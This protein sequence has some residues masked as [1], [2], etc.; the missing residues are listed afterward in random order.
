VKLSAN[1]F[2]IGILFLS[3]ILLPQAEA[4]LPSVKTCVLVLAC[5]G[6]GAIGGTVT[7]LCSPTLRAIR[8]GFVDLETQAQMEEIQNTQLFL[9]ESLQ[10]SCLQQANQRGI[11]L[12]EEE[13]YLLDLKPETISLSEIELLLKLNERLL[14]QGEKT[15]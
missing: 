13:R 6:V 8:S 2:K 1:F 14:I 12:S 7:T 4:K 10:K 11:S 9:A 5:T 15:K 3:V